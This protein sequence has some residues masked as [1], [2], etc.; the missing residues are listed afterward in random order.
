MRFFLCKLLI[1]AFIG[2]MAAPTSSVRGSLGLRGQ[3]GH[4]DAVFSVLAQQSQG[5]QPPSGLWWGLG[6][7]GAIAAAFWLGRRWGKATTDPPLAIDP[8]PDIAQS[9][10]ATLRQLEQQLADQ[11][12]ALAQAEER[13]QLVIEASVDGVWDWQ[14]L[15]D[16]VWW[17]PTLY[18]LLGIVPQAS[19]FSAPP[20]IQQRIHPDDRDTFAAVLQAHLKQDSPYQIEVR[21]QRADGSYGWFLCQGKALRTLEGEPYRMIGALSDISDRKQA[22]LALKASQAELQLITDSIPGGISYTD[23]QQ[24]YHFVNHTYE[25]WF[26]CAKADILGKTV[27]EVVGEAAYD[28]I[29]QYIERVLQG[30]TVAYEAQVPY[31]YQTRYVSAILIPDFS[32]APEAEILPESAAARSQVRGYYALITDISD[33][34][35][36]EAERQ[37]AIRAL[38]ESEARLRQ[39]NETLPI[40]FGLRTADYSHWLYVSRGYEILT[41]R[42]VQELYDNPKIWHQYV[43]PDDQQQ[44]QAQ[45]LASLPPQS[46]EAEFRLIHT[47]GDIRWLRANQEPILDEAGQ[48]IRVCSFIEDITDRKR[49]ELELQQAKEAAE[50]ANQAKSAFIANV[51][52]ELRSPL[53]AILGFARLLQQDLDLNADQ[54]ENAATIEHSGTHLLHIINQILDLAKI[55]ARRTTLNATQVDLWNLLDE[56]QTLFALPASDK[57]LH[58]SVERYPQIPHY[59]YTDGVK[60][61][62]VLI[63]LLDN[64]VKF[65]QQGSITLTVTSASAADEAE[66]GVVRF[67][68]A[69]TGPGIAPEDQVS[70]FDAFVQTQDGRQ[71]REGTGLG[72]TISREY[73]RLLGGQLRLQSQPGVGSRF[74]FELTAASMTE[75]APGSTAPRQSL[76]LTQTKPSYRILV[77]DNDAV[78]RRLL[79][80]TLGGIRADIQ[81]AAD[82]E[83]A[84]AQWQ[85]WRPHLILLDLRMPKLDGYEAARQI[86]QR[87]ADSPKSEDAAAPPTLII[88]ISATGLQ[89]QEQAAIAAGCNYF[90]RKPFQETELFDSL[91][92]LGIDYAYDPPEAQVPPSSQQELLEAVRQL[93]SSL[94]QPLKQS[95]IMGDSILIQ[96][97]I[98]NI[99]PIN[100]ELAANLQHLEAELKYAEI[101][102]YLRQVS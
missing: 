77:V 44:I 89:D 95:L 81:E 21:I 45:G 62:Q 98:R 3:Q 46:W 24:R 9:L 6:M 41:G 28:C 26:R 38:A 32:P 53:N 68:V 31:P 72:L 29:H 69:D 27:Q 48:V 14:I 100:Q 76:R 82:G 94:V 5:M 42:P 54:R 13:L 60:L 51:S 7:G 75:E 15:E 96:V 1:A 56:L 25:A 50:A 37:Q 23:D 59:I 10:Q 71:H 30:E 92:V 102:K 2:Q 34:K 57:G 79:R 87:E 20:A 70:L 78:N 12:I 101:L 17:S 39:M 67:S 74:W 63:N 93:P 36:G 99:W 33:R 91:K 55:E 61:R 40:F 90:L 4:D 86:R 83:Q 18:S 84:I 88:A 52:H 64:G 73:V 97:A 35:Q 11:T 66:H 47:S 49:I 58:F 19:E 16:R 85:S 80:Q 22:E 8:H 65:T 43:H